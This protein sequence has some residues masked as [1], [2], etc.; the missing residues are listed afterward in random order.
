MIFNYKRLHTHF[1]QTIEC[2]SS[3]NTRDA[4]AVQSVQTHRTVRRRQNP[5][6]RKKWTNKSKLT[7]KM[8]YDIKSMEYKK[9]TILNRFWA[10]LKLD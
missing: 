10:V 6:P 2:I 5:R 7:D 3:S 4:I 8:E 1:I 9:N